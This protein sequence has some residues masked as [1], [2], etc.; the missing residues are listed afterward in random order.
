MEWAQQAVQH[1]KQISSNKLKMYLM[2]AGMD[3]ECS[4]I[5]DTKFNIL[6]KYTSN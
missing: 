1:M 6:I 4:M 2:R 5:D 3:L